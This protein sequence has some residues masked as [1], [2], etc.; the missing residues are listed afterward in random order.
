MNWTP[1]T[2]EDKMNKSDW[3]RAHRSERKKRADSRDK[4]MSRYTKQKDTFDGVF[5]WLSDLVCKHWI[6]KIKRSSVN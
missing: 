1:P 4:Q 2:G 6:N 3:E 5:T